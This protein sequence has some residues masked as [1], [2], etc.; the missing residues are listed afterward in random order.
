MLLELLHP[1]LKVVLGLTE[2]NS[3]KEVLGQL[4]ELLR[5]VHDVLLDVFEIQQR[6]LLPRL[7]PSL[8]LRDLVGVR[9][10]L[11]GEDLDVLTVLFDQGIGLVDSLV[12]GG[13]LFRGYRK[14]EEL[15]VVLVVENFHVYA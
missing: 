4:P 12:D 10:D 5:L 14:L 7:L 13:F 8:T 9:L 6:L 11:F 15:A 1:I 3:L 2:A